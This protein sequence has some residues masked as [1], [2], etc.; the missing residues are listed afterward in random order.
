MIRGSRWFGGNED[1]PLEQA[2][3]TVGV[4][5]RR[6]ELPTLDVLARLDEDRIALVPDVRPVERALA[7]ELRGDVVRHPVEP[8]PVAQALRPGRITP[9]ELALRVVED[10]LVDGRSGQLVKIG[11]RPDVV[12]VEVGDEDGSDAPARGLERFSPDLLRVRES[13]PRVDEGPAVLAREEIRVHVPRP[14]RERQRDPPYSTV[15]LV[16]PPTLQPARSRIDPLASRLSGQHDREDAGHLEQERVDDELA[17]GMVGPFA[18]DEPQNWNRDDRL[19]RERRRHKPT[20]GCHDAGKHG[21]RRQEENDRER[22]QPVI[23]PGLSRRLVLRKAREE[24]QC[25]GCKRQNDGVQRPEGDG[26]SV[27]HQGRLAA[28]EHV[29]Y[30]L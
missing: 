20:P 17:V 14:C 26:I 2:E 28:Y 10:S 25:P 29:F 3:L 12:W 27:R 6:D 1:A 9:D 8:E 16:H 23:G 4:A 11:R 30:H 22:C 19:N 13:H 18:Y 24:K 7:H 21:D 5:R 15:Q